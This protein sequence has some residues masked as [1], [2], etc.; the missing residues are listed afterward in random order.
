VYSCL[1]AAGAPVAPSSPEQDAAVVDVAASID[2]ARA[3][4]AQHLVERGATPEQASSIV[5]ALADEDV[6]VLAE[7]PKMLSSASANSTLIT[8]AIFLA[9]IATGVTLIVLASN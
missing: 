6:R 9:V 7:N 8:W 5:G 2:G 1:V 3:S 4:L